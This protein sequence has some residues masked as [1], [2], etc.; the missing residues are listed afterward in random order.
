MWWMLVVAC[1]KVEPAPEEL[2][3][4]LHWVWQ[5]YD[6]GTDEEL[7]E[8]L[9][10]LDRAV[11]GATFEEGSD[12]SL[13]RLSSSEAELV[14]VTDRDPA[15]APGV[16]LVNRFVCGMGQLEEI[17][18]YPDQ[19]ELYEGVYTDYGR[20]FD[21][22]RE[23]WL[24]GSIP[25][26][27]YDIEYTASI[28]GATYTA[29][30]RGALRR[31]PELDEESTPFGAFVLQRSYMPEPGVFE[32][33]SSSK[34]MDQD[35]QLELYWKRGDETLHAYGMWRQASYGSGIDME[36]DGSQRLLLNSLFDWDDDTAT[37]CEE[38]RP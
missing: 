29:R 14:G 24:A 21:T 26:L 2:D 11:D 35:Y 34:T 15:L 12:G 4:L 5:R 38:G 33:A 37:L 27:D 25:R 16:F 17:L 32:D 13:S 10:N 30:S 3:E 23:D 1:K 28:L 8:A 36:N 6:E 20:S 31:V 19:S 7:A 18:S 22:S 9:R